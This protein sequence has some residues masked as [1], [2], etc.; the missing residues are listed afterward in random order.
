MTSKQVISGALT[1]LLVPLLIF[2]LTS[3]M[4]GFA[5]A[6][7]VMVLENKVETNKS[8]AK[9]IKDDIKEI[10]GDVKTLLQR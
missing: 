6:D 5:R 4:S 3:Y 10:K 7:R 1:L 2:L 8:V 9:E